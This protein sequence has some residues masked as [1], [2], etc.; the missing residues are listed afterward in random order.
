VI[1]RRG[2]RHESIIRELQLTSEGVQ[3]GEP[4]ESFQGILS[5]I[6]RYVGEETALLEK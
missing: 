2:G 5:G 3:V 4:L 6:P 1:K